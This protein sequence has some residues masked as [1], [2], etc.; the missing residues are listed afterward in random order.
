MYCI[1]KQQL[2]NKLKYKIDVIVFNK[3]RTF[4]LTVLIAIAAS[5]IDIDVACRLVRKS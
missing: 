4:M 5:A 3:T 2:K 1:L